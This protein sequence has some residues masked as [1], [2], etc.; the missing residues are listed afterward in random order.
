MSRFSPEQVTATVRDPP[1]RRFPRGTRPAPSP[2]RTPPTPEQVAR[3][4]ASLCGVWSRPPRRDGG[5]EAIPRERGDVAGDSFQEQARRLCGSQ[6]REKYASCGACGS[7]DEPP[8]SA[9]PPQV[10]V[11]QHGTG[12]ISGQPAGPPAEEGCPRNARRRP[13]GGSPARG[14]LWRAASSTAVPEW[15]ASRPGTPGANR[16]C[17]RQ[18]PPRRATE[19]GV[20]GCAG[21]ETG[22]CGA[23]C[24]RLCARFLP[25]GDAFAA[26]GRRVYLRPCA[27]TGHRRCSGPCA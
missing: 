1:P 6:V 10:S 15:A 7:K 19:R 13:P 8:G 23:R 20:L 16:V 12:H 3:R 14:P 17:R 5:G 18:V 25:L 24:R 11:R 4:S 22:S 27:T 26:Q 21:Q 2:R 9:R